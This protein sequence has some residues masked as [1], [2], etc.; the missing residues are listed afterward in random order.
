M[1]PVPIT[2]GDGVRRTKIMRM[3]FSLLE[4]KMGAMVSESLSM[5]K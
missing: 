3:H 1:A 5:T 2:R 4:G